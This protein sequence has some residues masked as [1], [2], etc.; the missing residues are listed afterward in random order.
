MIF[1]VIH[2]FQKLA[3]QSEG[4]KIAVFGK[5]VLFP[6]DKYY[7]NSESLVLSRFSSFNRLIRRDITDSSHQFVFASMRSNKYE[8]LRTNG[9]GRSAA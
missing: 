5:I 6:Y 2:C 9:S 1:L 7:C 4:E 3:L 8:I